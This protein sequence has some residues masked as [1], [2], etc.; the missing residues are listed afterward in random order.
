MRRDRHVAARAVVNRA[1]HDEPLPIHLAGRLRHIG[2]ASVTAESGL[3]GVIYSERSGAGLGFPFSTRSQSAS[4]S[5]DRGIR[6]SP[7]A[8]QIIFAASPTPPTAST[9]GASTNIL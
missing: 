5:G 9:C 8:G 6:V 2:P 1:G 4:C 3:V 7:R